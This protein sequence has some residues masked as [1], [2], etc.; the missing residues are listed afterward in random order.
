MN[1][2]AQKW[3]GSRIPTRQGRDSHKKLTTQ[4]HTG[5]AR[6]QRRQKQALPQSNQI[7]DSAQADG[8]LRGSKDPSL[9]DTRQFNDVT[10]IRQLRSNLHGAIIRSANGNARN[11]P[12]H[13]TSAR[14]KKRKTN[15][16]QVHARFCK[17]SSV[18]LRAN[19]PVRK[20]KK[21]MQTQRQA[22]DKWGL[23]SNLKRPGTE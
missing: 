6:L 11:T 18:Q 15:Y 9:V 3:S 21:Q 23:H 14:Q 10:M 1:T 20:S 5:S 2:Q 19:E 4:L 16:L 12:R 22:K 8:P 13:N 7:S 17:R